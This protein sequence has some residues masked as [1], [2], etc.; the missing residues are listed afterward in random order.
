MQTGL[1]M[2]SF[3]FAF[4][5]AGPPG[6]VSP[7]YIHPV[8]PDY[9]GVVDPVSTAEMPKANAKALFDITSGKMDKGVIKGLDRAALF[10]NLYG[11]AGVL[12]K[13]IRVAVILHG[14][15]TK[16]ALNNRAY[17]EVSEGKGNPNLE[18]I[19]RLKESG[20][21]I[22]VCLQALA[23][24]KYS[25]NDVL[26]EIEIAAAAST[27]NMNKQMAGYAYLPFH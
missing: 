1:F 15:A 5:S 7:E 13:Q 4:I 23:Y 6:T 9:G 26:P 16:A 8:I 2:L 21:E 10:L 25:R 22:Y 18:L 3:L 27:V 20:V 14:D 17:G 24:Q 11:A 12:P 19:Q